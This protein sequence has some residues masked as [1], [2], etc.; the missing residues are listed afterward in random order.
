MVPQFHST[1]GKS[2]VLGRIL[3]PKVTQPG[4]VFPETITQVVSC[5]TCCC[6][7]GTLSCPCSSGI[8][9]MSWDFRDRNM[10]EIVS[11]LKTGSG[12]VSATQHFLHRTSGY[13]HTII[14]WA[15][16][17]KIWKEALSEGERCKYKPSNYTVWP[18]F[19]FLILW[20]PRPQFLC[21]EGLKAADWV[22]LFL[23]K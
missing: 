10:E 20:N 1:H 15:E 11:N 2:K 19:C 14:K 18:R 12:H 6:L 9:S 3:V 22:L 13:T 5:R 16:M 4:S 17:L 8:S 21:F 7:L 23:W